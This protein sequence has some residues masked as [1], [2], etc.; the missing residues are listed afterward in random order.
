MTRYVINWRFFRVF[1]Y[2]YVQMMIEDRWPILETYDNCW[3][4]RSMLKLALKSSAETSRRTAQRLITERMRG[5]LAG[6]SPH[7]QTR[8]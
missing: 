1:V 7:E 4:V 2:D 3:P 6:S 5:A 8:V